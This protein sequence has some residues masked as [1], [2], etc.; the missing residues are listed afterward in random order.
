MTSAGAFWDAIAAGDVR[1][2][3]AE[4]ALIWRLRALHWSWD[5]IARE[6]LAARARR[7]SRAAHFARDLA[8]TKQARKAYRK[9]GEPTWQA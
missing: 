9:E 4:D 3:A 2:T 1:L 5:F 7:R 6:L 8:S